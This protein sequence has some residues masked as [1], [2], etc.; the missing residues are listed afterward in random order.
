MTPGRTPA[1]TINATPVASHDVTNG[2]NRKRGRSARH[3][4]DS[5]YSGSDSLAITSPS[6]LSW[7]GTIC[8][9]PSADAH[10]GCSFFNS[11]T[12]ASTPALSVEPLKTSLNA[13]R[14]D[15]AHVAAA[16]AF[17]CAA[18]AFF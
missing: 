10:W 5:P 4:V 6:S 7:Y 11:A 8:H 17:T 13:D 1:A 12:V 15:C 2:N 16:S 9:W 3:A 18:T 14:N